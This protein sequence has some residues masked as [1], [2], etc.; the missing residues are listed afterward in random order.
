M[1]GLIVRAARDADLDALLD[2]ERLASHDPWGERAIRSQLASE[3]G[4]SLV[5]EEDGAVVGSLYLSLCAP[6]SEVLAL[7]VLPCARRRGIGRLLLENGMKILKSGGACVLY[8]D[9]RVSN[10]PARALYSSLGFRECGRRRGFYSAPKEDAILM[11]RELTDAVPR[12]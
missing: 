12:N 4:V 1:A 5:C 6:E 8:L 2:I 7:A 9:V 3:V 10:A 11:E